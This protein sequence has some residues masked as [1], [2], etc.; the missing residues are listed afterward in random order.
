MR[1]INAEGINIGGAGR[2]AETGLGDKGV[3]TL[4]EPCG[5]RQLIDPRLKLLDLQGDHAFGAVHRAHCAA[6]IRNRLPSALLGIDLIQHEAITC[7]AAR[8]DGKR[9]CRAR[10]QAH[11][12]GCAG[13]FINELGPA[14]AEHNGFDLVFGLGAFQRFRGLCRAIVL[15]DRADGFGLGHSPFASLS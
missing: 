5:R 8:V 15:K 7:R 10:C 13:K 3:F 14:I 1:S 9:R 11:R 6:I 4:L 12:R 2:R